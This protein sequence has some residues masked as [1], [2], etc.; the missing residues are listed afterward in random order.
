M[1]SVVRDFYQS[2]Q[3]KDYTTAMT[4]TNVAEDEASQVADL[5]AQMNMD[6]MDFGVDSSRIDAGDTTATVFVHLRVSSVY[7]NDTALG[8]PSIPCAKRDGKW[9]VLFM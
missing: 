3:N 1:E 7:A 8:T 4:Y 6:I 2:V 9:I 5:L